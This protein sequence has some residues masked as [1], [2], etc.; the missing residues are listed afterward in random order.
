MR[1]IQL[2][3]LPWTDV[4]AI[5]D[6]TDSLP[7]KGNW[8]AKAKRW[9]VQG[10][11]DGKTYNKGPRSPEDIHTI[12]IHHSGPP[13]GTIKSH[14][15]YHARKWGCGI[16]YHMVIDKGRIYQTNDLL[17]MTYHSGNNNTYT[18]GICVN[19]DLSNSEMT[20]LERKLLYSAILTVKSLLPIT[21]IKGHRELPASATACPCTSEDRIRKDI[22]SLEEQI[23]Y[24]NT[25]SAERVLSYAFAERINDLGTKFNDIKWGV[26]A[27]AKVMQ[28]AVV[29]EQLG[30]TGEVTPEGIVKRVRDI[31][32]NS[33]MAK[34]EDEGF[35]KLLIGANKAKEVGLL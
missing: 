22:E 2:T 31:Y 28:L 14:A 21:N 13:N 6:I 17:S 1:G 30:Y 8:D 26:P 23:E 34:Y 18:V 15:E 10:V 29:M 19:R 24:L 27:K 33:A 12:V 7:K 3:K 4:P 11:W 5:E 32:N 16:A 9:V 20:D 25:P 35:K